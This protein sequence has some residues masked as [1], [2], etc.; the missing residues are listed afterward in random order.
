MGH[1]QRA[2]ST[3]CLCPRRTSEFQR[4]KLT[5]VAGQ[6][7]GPSDFVV[8]N[9]QEQPLPLYGLS[10]ACRER[11]RKRERVGQ[12]ARER[13]RVSELE[14]E[15]IR[16]SELSLLCS[17]LSASN[18]CLPACLSVCLLASLQMK[19]ISFICSACV[20]SPSFN[21][22]FFVAY[23]FFGAGYGFSAPFDGEFECLS[24]M[25]HIEFGQF[26]DEISIN[27]R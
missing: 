20:F 8:G 15:R 24:K 11:E 4:L 3:N 5:F 16:S 7:L 13:S 21:N 22:S 26:K 27:M 18:S 25:F 17:A 19:L 6:T 14:V 23:C 2:A 10:F 12:R 1:V 9:Q